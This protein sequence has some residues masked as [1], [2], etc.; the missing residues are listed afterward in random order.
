[1]NILY[2]YNE[3]MGYTL[4]TINEITKKNIK[5]YI[6]YKKARIDLLNSLKKN[7]NIFLYKKNS[8]TKKE[9]L[10]IIESMKPYII[11][12]SG[13]KDIDYLLLAK[14]FLANH[15]IVVCGM[16]NIP[17]ETAK[18]K[19]LILINKF[20]V[21]KFFFS[22]IWVA[23]NLQYQLARDLGFKKNEIISNLYSADYCFFNIFKKRMS[24]IKLSGNYPHRFLFVGRLEYIKGVDLLVNAWKKIKNKR[25]DWELHLI[26][27]G[28][29]SKSLKEVKDITVKN[30]KNSK[31][32]SLEAIQAGCFIL[33][34]RNENW[35]VVV[36]EFAS[37]GLPLIL[38]S[39]VGSSE[40][41]LKQKI[42]GYK[43]KS[44]N[45]DSL[46]KCLVG[47]INTSDERLYEMSL[48]SNQE[49]KKI[50][51]KISANSLLSLK[52]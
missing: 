5:V 29:L 7:P 34:S 24:D 32:L 37:S 22:N 15:S 35:G 6:I 18:Q 44:N 51:P 23:G 9:T 50:N 52:K 16:D 14:K 33:P 38:S 25:K 28:S 49:A 3:L 20:K 46:A 42:N 43:F 13:W 27:D 11:V 1:M 19:I 36:H 10:E 41:F 21:L 48:I 4:T 17:N 2:L 30:F 26:G 39:N 12:V 45:V 8:L 31:E 40:T 47:I